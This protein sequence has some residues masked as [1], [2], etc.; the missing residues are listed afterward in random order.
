MPD[1]G[2]G[3][4]LRTCVPLKASAFDAEGKKVFH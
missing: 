1:G 2:C 3:E 4:Q